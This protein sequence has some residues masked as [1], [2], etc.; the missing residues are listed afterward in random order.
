MV[1]LQA[2]NLKPA[3]GRAPRGRLLSRGVVLSLLAHA[4][5]GTGLLAIAEYADL[6]PSGAEERSSVNLAMF[7]ASR[8]EFVPEAAEPEVALEEFDV[9]EEPEL[10][11]QPFVPELLQPADPPPPAPLDWNPPKDTVNRVGSWEPRFEP[12]PEELATE[13]RVAEEPTVPKEPE[14]EP[15]APQVLEGDELPDVLEAPLPKY[16]RQARRMSWEGTV[17]LVIQVDAA[18]NVTDLVVEKSSGHK[19]LDESAC[20]AFRRWVFQPRKNG[21]PVVRHL[22]KPFTF[23]LR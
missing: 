14:D 4:A 20:K 15:D 8:A 6:L 2:K 23:R 17:V 22:R 7:E 11:E 21:E 19:S 5:V 1:D 9:H 16:P 13:E 3:K 12:A 18:G 10:I